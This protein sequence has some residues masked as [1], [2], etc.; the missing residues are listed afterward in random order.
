MFGKSLSKEQELKLSKLP[1]TNI[2]L[3][4]D[5]D[6]AGREAKLQITRQLNRLYTLSFPRILTKDIGEMTV[7]QIKDNI[8]PQLKG[9]NT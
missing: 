3:L 1:I 7:Q 8:L 9:Q 2:V 4:T 5:N 6:Q